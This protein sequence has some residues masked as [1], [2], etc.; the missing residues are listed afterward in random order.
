[1]RNFILIFISLFSF[2]FFYAQDF[3]GKAYYKS[4]TSFDLGSWGS[5]MS[6]EQKNQ[7]K[8]RMKNML[9]KTFGVLPKEGITNYPRNPKFFYV[10]FKLGS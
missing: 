10:S 8:A 1:M 7:M 5:T 2:N 4:K 9:E 6:T 3:Q